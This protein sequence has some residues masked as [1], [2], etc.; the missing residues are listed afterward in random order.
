MTRAWLMLAAAALP[1]YPAFAQ[2]HGGHSG[3]DGHEA[4]APAP[5]PHAGHAM[6]KAEPDPHAGHALPETPAPDPHAGHD[7]SGT[8]VDIPVGPPPAEALQGPAHAA[9]AVWG[10][11]MARSRSILWSEHGGMPTAKFLIDRAETRLR[12]GRDGW[13]LDGEGW[14]GGDIDKLWL[15][16]EVEGDWGKSPE[17]AEVQALWS[18]AIGPFFDLQAG[19]RYDIEPVGRARLAVGVEGL[20]PYWIELDAAA[21]VST[22]GDVTARIKA[23]HDVRIT[24]SLILQ[25]SIELDFAAQDISEEGIGAGLSNAEVGLRLRYQIEPRFAP[26]VG[27]NLDRAFGKT[28]RFAKAE[29]EDAGPLSLV[30]GLHAWF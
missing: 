27:V 12:N 20:A 30:I 10:G 2:D 25:P 1:A 14:I 3:H 5:D 15:K 6:P 19:V 29:G 26:Y 9:D 8:A 21:F 17:S 11:P 16:T 18:H 24:Q 28:R 22:R 7:M 13:A 23:E 4:P